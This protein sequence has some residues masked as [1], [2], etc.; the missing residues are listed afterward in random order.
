[1]LPSAP[2]QIVP[3]LGLASALLLAYRGMLAALLALAALWTVQSVMGDYFPNLRIGVSE[4]LVMLGFAALGIALRNQLLGGSQRW[5]S[6]AWAVYIAVVVAVMIDAGVPFF[7]VHLPIVLAI[8]VVVGLAAARL[9][10]WIHRGRSEPHAGWVAMLSL[11]ALLSLVWAHLVVMKDAVI[12]LI[13]AATVGPMIDRPEEWWVIGLFS[14]LLLW[15]L[16]SSLQVLVVRISACIDDLRR[17]ARVAMALLRGQPVSAEAPAARRADV[18]VRWWHPV[19]LIGALRSLTKWAGIA[20][21]VAA[22]AR[23]I[24][25]YGE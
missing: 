18:D 6:A 9:H 5:W 3:L 11:V 2:Q 17:A 15:L 19:H 13:A 22:A 24:A 21:E 23:P 20:I 10:S 16:L 7:S 25:E 1:V 8:V 12:Q 4:V 14:I